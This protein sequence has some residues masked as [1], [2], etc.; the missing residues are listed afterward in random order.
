MMS[1]SPFATRVWPRCRSAWTRVRFAPIPAAQTR[2]DAIKGS[3]N[4]SRSPPL[5]HPPRGPSRCAAIREGRY[6]LAA[7][8]RSTTPRYSFIGDLGRESGIIGGARQHHVHL[9]QAP[10]KIPQ[11][12]RSPRAARS[13]TEVAI[14]PDP[15]GR[16]QP[17]SVQLHPSPWLRIIPVPPPGYAVRRPRPSVPSR[18]A[19]GGYGVALFGQVAAHLGLGM[20]AADD[21]A[22]IFS[23]ATSPTISELLD[24]C[25]SQLMVASGAMLTSRIREVG[26]KISAVVSGDPPEFVET[27]MTTWTK[28]GSA[29]ASVDPAPRRTRARASCDGSG[30]GLSSQATDSGSGQRAVPPAI[31]VSIS[32]AA[33]RGPA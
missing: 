6:E 32:A 10:A 27:S 22:E 11:W 1:T 8:P 4:A 21:A 31:C 5:R 33:R 2:R 16:G 24:C 9:A 26:S 3:R 30:P 20:R 23:I 29:K 19:A 15:K 28:D 25:G 12:F 18:P 7:P 17:S 13:R 14:V